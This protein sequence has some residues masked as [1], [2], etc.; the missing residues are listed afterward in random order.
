MA[1]DRKDYTVR[2]SD[3][4][5]IE[6]DDYRQA[7]WQQCWNR[8]TY[9]FRRWLFVGRP[10]LD[11]HGNAEG[12][13]HAG[14][15][16]MVEAMRDAVW[17]MPAKRDTSK[18][19]YCVSGLV[20]WFE[21]LDCL[22]AA[23]RPVTELEEIDRALLESFM[24]WLRHTKAAA[25]DNGRLSYTSAK[26][27]YSH[28]K[29]VL[30]YLVRQKVLPEGIFPRN[31]FPNS[32]RAYTSHKPYKK[33]VMT[34]LLRAL[35]EDIRGVRE[36]TLNISDSETLS[37]Y[38][39]VIAAR[40]GRNPDPLFKMTFDALRPHPI[41]PDKLMLLVTYKNR[42]NSTS[43]QGLQCQW[44]I[45]DMASLPMDAVTL[46]HEVS[47]MTLPLVAGASPGVRDR[48]WLFRAS[49]SG[50]SVKD[51][52]TALNKDHFKH[53]V[54]NIINRH[55]LVDENGKPLKLN[56]SRLRATFSERMW[57][58]TGGDILMTAQLNGNSP[59]V[60]DRHYLAATPEMEANHRRLG[61]IMH[62]D[63]SGAGDDENKLEELSMET[64][65]P[66]PQLMK[67]LS[68]ENNT[69]VGRCCD[70]R[71]GNKAPG[72]GRLCTCWRECFDCPDQVVMESD[73]YRLFS[74]YWLLTDERNFISLSRWN[75]LYAPIIH[76]IDNEI[77][78]PNLR[79]QDNSKGCF[80]TYRVNKYREDA[81]SNPH[82]MWRD[83]TI[84]GGFIEAT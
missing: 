57:Q 65:I 48:L 30:Q 63:W 32:N 41:K 26:I 81:R 44:Q 59:A 3:A 22:Y 2:G 49:G 73:L 12:L 47:K 51:Q 69:G 74:F 50:S 78:A 31:P 25:T 68:G 58:L 20:N 39:L 76:K 28:S 61:F 34:A 55:N 35:A 46:F 71:H 36:G 38:L 23:G 21:Y 60:T 1:R 82:L 56:I 29:T 6:I 64:G 84:L 19:S 9:D 15:D 66:V 77:V 72:D 62:A 8:N 52:V 13:L 14:R 45:E 83:R 10:E 5:V 27:V 80:D 33:M 18:E 53:A 43:I 7:P 4:N 75:E 42:G 67:I 79:T 37:V 16:K 40:T 24:H 70:P 54:L 17:H 11:R